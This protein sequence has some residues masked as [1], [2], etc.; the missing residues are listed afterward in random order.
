M[1]NTTFWS[2]VRQMLLLSRFWCNQERLACAKTD[3]LPHRPCSARVHME[4]VLGVRESRHRVIVAHGVAVEVGAEV[5]DAARAV[6]AGNALRGAVPTTAVVDAAVRC[7]N[8]ARRNRVDEVVPQAGLDGLHSTRLGDV[9]VRRAVSVRSAQ[10]RTFARLFGGCGTSKRICCGGRKQ[11][12]DSD[13]AIRVAVC[14]LAVRM[15]INANTISLPAHVASLV[16][17]I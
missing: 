1:R 10:D 15:I 7:A 6:D 4:T 5:R 14:S 16:I 2:A 13:L 3:F 17:R 9:H 12:A 8:A 11:V